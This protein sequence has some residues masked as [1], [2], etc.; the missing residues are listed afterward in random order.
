MVSE[1]IKPRMKSVRSYL[2]HVRMEEIIRMPLGIKKG[3]KKLK[4]DLK[5]N[6]EKRK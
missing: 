5:Q 4:P 2:W 1:R 3:Q 6:S